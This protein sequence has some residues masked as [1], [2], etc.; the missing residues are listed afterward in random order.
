MEQMLQGRAR[1]LTIRDWRR[2]RRRPP[3]WALDILQEFL[4]SRG[5]N[6]LEIA[7]QLEN[8]NQKRL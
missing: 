4:R 8:E 1:P 2:G 6:M 3:S 7:D 5:R